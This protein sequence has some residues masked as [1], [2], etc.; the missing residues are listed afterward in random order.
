MLGDRTLMKNL[1]KVTLL[2]CL[3]QFIFYMKNFLMKYVPG[4]VFDNTAV[5]QIA[6]MIAILLAVAL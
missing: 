3:V 1:V 6:E 4:D 2:W 5:A